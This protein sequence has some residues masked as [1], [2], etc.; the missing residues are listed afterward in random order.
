MS[1][2]EIRLHKRFAGNVNSAL[3]CLARRVE[4][5]PFRYPIQGKYRGQA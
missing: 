1:K 2:R 4:E 3:Y 5:K